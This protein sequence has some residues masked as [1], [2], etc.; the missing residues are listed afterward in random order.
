MKHQSQSDSFLS[1]SKEIGKSKSK[2]QMIDALTETVLLV[3]KELKT[4]LN[5]Q[6]IAGILDYVMCRGN[7]K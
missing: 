5:E 2:H 4:T 3:E 6:Q 1:I 7:E